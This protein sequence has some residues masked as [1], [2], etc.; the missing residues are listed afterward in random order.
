MRLGDL[1]TSV[2]FASEICSMGKSLGA[3][4]VKFV[5]FYINGPFNREKLV[6]LKQ[7]EMRRIS[8]FK[9]LN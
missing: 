5:W 1:V 4:L 9:R 2:G 3:N 8:P 7:E 6:W